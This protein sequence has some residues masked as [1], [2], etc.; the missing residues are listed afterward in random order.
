MIAGVDLTNSCCSSEFAIQ[1]FY[2]R[3]CNQQKTPFINMKLIW[4]AKPALW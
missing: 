2:Q 4:V 1:K 3:I